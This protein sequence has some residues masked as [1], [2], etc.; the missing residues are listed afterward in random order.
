MVGEEVCRTGLA[1]T[2]ALCAAFD[3][4]TVSGGQRWQFSYRRGELV[5]QPTPVSTPELACTKIELELDTTLL[6]SG[7]VFSASGLDEQL[8]RASGL[9]PRM[10]RVCFTDMQ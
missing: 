2:N 3:V 7:L 1:V 6:Q 5:N 10:P 9:L 4:E 8:K